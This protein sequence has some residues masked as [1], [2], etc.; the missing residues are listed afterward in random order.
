MLHDFEEWYSEKKVNYGYV[1]LNII[2]FNA[3]VIINDV[4]YHVALQGQSTWSEPK[5]WFVH[6]YITVM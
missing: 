5:F 6:L 4:K 1:G 2:N 3:Y